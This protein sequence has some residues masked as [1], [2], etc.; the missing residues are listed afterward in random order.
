MLC[1]RARRRLRFE[2][3]V[4]CR[5]ALYD[6]GAELCK[7]YVG[8]LSCSHQEYLFLEQTLLT[9]ERLSRSYLFDCRYLGY[10]TN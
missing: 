4:R 3:K 7:R 5:D 10:Q 2:N 1:C 9:I 6:R 8:K